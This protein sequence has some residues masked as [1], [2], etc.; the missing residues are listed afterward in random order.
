M[1]KRLKARIIERYGTQAD[2]SVAIK[3]DETI[4]SRVIRGRRM[5]DPKTQEKWAH[6]LGSTVAELFGNDR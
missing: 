1:N 2:F 3:T 4:V 5:L 6:K